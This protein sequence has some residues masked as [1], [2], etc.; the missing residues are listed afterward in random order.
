MTV[1]G[2]R[3]HDHAEAHTLRTVTRTPGKGLALLG[4]M[5]AFDPLPYCVGPNCVLFDARIVCA[6]RG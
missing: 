2:Q 5:R 4:G 1:M 3:H 6:K